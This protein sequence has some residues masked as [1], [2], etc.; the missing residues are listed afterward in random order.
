MIKI[1]FVMYYS[2]L[3]NLWPNEYIMCDSC[4][5]IGKWLELIMLITYVL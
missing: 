2:Y 4:F 1:I 3:V 5:Y